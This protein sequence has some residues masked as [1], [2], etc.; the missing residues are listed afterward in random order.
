MLLEHLGITVKDLEDS[1]RFYTALFGEEPV[2]RVMWRGDN[3]VYVADMLGQ[4]GLT[5][6]AAFFRIPGS[7]ALLEV[8]QY[9]DLDDGEG[10]ALKHH[11]T[12]GVHIGFYVSSIE[13]AKARVQ[14]AGSY[15]LSEPVQIKHGPYLG[16][17]GRAVLFRDPD[18]NNL[19][20]MEVTSR[21]GNVPLPAA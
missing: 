7:N 10:P 16:T 5:L 15:F 11:E 17:G 3:A 6:D 8:I 2:E 9:H 14:A 13:V 18:G 4:P 1:V 20:L 12:G 19:Q 21:P